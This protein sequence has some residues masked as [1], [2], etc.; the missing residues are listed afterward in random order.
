MRSYITNCIFIGRNEQ[1]IGEDE[2]GLWIR[3]DR[4]VVMPIEEYAAI[5]R[6][7]MLP[8]CPWPRAA[9]NTGTVQE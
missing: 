5:V 9:P 7:D 8:P 6:D 2:N 4:Y 3:M 1:I